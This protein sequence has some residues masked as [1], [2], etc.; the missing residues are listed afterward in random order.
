MWAMTPAD[1]REL[2]AYR[3]TGLTP[4]QVARLKDGPLPDDEGRAPLPL[5]DPAE[6]SAM[7][8]DNAWDEREHTGLLDE[9]A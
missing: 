6:Y 9:E 8:Y 4:E 3:A 7:N 1:R 5:T 2:D